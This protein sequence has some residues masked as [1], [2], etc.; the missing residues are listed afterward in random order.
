ML[1]TRPTRNPTTEKMRGVFLCPVDNDREAR[2]ET[3]YEF[4]MWLA[5]G[6]TVASVPSITD[7]ALLWEQWAYHNGGKVSE[8]DRRAEMNVAFT[9]GHTRWFRLSDTTSSR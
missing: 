2:P 6:Q 1:N 4:K 3:S 9:D 7:M 8:H 5:E